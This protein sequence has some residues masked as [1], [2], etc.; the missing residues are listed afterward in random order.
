MSDIAWLVLFAVALR[1]VIALAVPYVSY[2]DAIYQTLEPAHKLAFGTGLL[3]W[4]FVLGIRSWLLPGIL[5][6]LMRVGAL[7][8]A[9]PDAVL[10]PG[11]L[12]MASASCAPVICGYLWGNRLLGRSGALVVAFANAVWVDNLYYATQTLTEVAAGDCLFVALYLGSTA[13]GS[14]RG[15]FWCGFAFGLSFAFRFHLGP[16]ILI[17][18]LWLCRREIGRRLPVLLLG[19]APPVLALGLIDWLSWGS[20]FQSI[21]LNAGINV[22]EGVGA[23]FGT[24]PWYQ[25]ALYPIEAWTIAAPVLVWGAIKGTRRMPLAAL[26]VLA[27][28]VTHG[29]V[30]HKEHRFVE[31]AFALIVSLTA[32]AAVEAWRGRAAAWAVRLPRF[33]RGETRL[34]AS[35]WAGMSLLVALLPGYNHTWFRERTALDLFAY[36]SAIDPAPCGVG[37]Y[38][39]DSGSVPGQ[40]HLP[41]AT[42]LYEMD[43]DRF[44][45]E[46]NAVDTIVA[47]AGTDIPDPAFL[48]DRCF[49]VN[50]DRDIHGKTLCDW[51]RRGVCDRTQAPPPKY[52]W[53]PAIATRYSPLSTIQSVP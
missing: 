33:L 47:F 24:S 42:P 10:F 25:M 31:P 40:S 16:A 36:L 1:V 7:M 32:V 13:A 14:R 21:W 11:T 20:P 2:H 8:G 49:T 3:P 50:W 46:Q 12:F 5:A 41:L 44:A 51:R 34:Y 27:I 15:L 37:L 53:P 19:A 38:G 26:A 35:A 43:K 45:G 48:S 52:H 9:T 17:A 29:L 30:G 18:V 22:W 23:N 6:G 39:V 28:F 4:E